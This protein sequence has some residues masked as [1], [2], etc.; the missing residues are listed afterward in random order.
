M[1]TKSIKP[2]RDDGLLSKGWESPQERAPSIM[3]S[4]TPS[5]A[6]I[7]A[8]FSLL[9]TFVGALAILMSAYEAETFLKARI[10]SRGGTFLI[11]LGM[12]GLLFHAFNETEIQFRRLYGAFGTALLALGYIF[13]FRFGKQDYSG[14]FLLIGAPCYALSWCFLLCYF[15]NETEETLRIWVSR[16]MGATALLMIATGVIGSLLP[17]SGYGSDFLLGRGVVHLI[18]G[19]LFVGGCVSTLSIEN[20]WSYWMPFG[21]GAIGVM[22]IVLGAGWSIPYV[23]PMFKWLP[24]P[25]QQPGAPFLF[26][27]A[28]LEFLLLSVGICSD[29]KFVVMARRELASFFYSPI[30]YFV[31]IGFAIFGGFSFVS[32]VSAITDPRVGAIREPII[33]YYMFGYVSITSLVLLVPVITM[34]QLSEEQR[35][36]TMEVLLTAPVT[37]TMIVLSK[38]FA[39]WRFYL[40]AWYPW[41]LY[42]VAL[43]VEG[44]A[45]FDYRPVLSFALAL[46]IT[47]AAFVAMGIFFSSVTKNQVVAAVLS[48]L[49][50]LFPI[51]LYLLKGTIASNPLTGTSGS[52]AWT[53]FLTY[54][55]FVDLWDQALMGR[56]APRFYLFYISSAVFWLFLTIKVLESRKWR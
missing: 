31:L 21:V 2:K 32:F 55:N 3:R 4:D 19:L 15:R 35:L 46:A 36:G 30:A 43:R 24:W 6:R 45:P 33:V 42:L 40:L 25:P 51:F 52:S 28:G 7:I 54:V 47:G 17:A 5:P 10:G 23:S 53:T 27:Y 1:P 22:M 48:L 56:V 49:G 34:R 44:G 26:I 38:F 11:L 18:L 13:M 50:M 41:G 12:A 16:A 39:A 14:Q 29:N 9:T 8:F 37:E 20:P